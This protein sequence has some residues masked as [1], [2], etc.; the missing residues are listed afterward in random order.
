MIETITKYGKILVTGGK[1]YDNNKR[2][3]KS[4]SAKRNASY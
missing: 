2:F 4:K 3:I 1:V